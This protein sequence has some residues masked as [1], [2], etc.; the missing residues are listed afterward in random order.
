[1]IARFSSQRH[2]VHDVLAYQNNTLPHIEQLTL[3]GYTQKSM[4]G[5]LAR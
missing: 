3:P 5:T 2:L 4:L 1:M